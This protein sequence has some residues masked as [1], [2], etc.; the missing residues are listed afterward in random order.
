MGKYSVSLKKVVEDNS[1]GIL[2]APK[3][4]EDVYVTSQDVNRPGLMLAGYSAYFDAERIQFLGLAEMNYISSLDEDAAA[5]SMERLMATEPVAVVIT[6]SLECPD[7]LREYAQKYSVPI[8]TSDPDKPGFHFR[9]YVNS[10]I[11]SGRRARPAHHAPRS[12]CRS[13][14]RGCPDP[15]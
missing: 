5:A 7:K 11:I 6:R 2:Y 13:Q 1:L 10:Y 3:P 14:R 12:A 15:R 8:L 9:L 4:V